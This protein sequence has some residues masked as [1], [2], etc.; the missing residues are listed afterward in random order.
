[1]NKVISALAVVGF[2][3]LLYLF[4]AGAIELID[5]LKQALGK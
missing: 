5:Q 2:C 4:G 1:M 3:T